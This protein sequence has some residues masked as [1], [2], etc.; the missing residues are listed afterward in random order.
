MVDSNLSEATMTIWKWCE[1]EEE[2]YEHA[3][4]M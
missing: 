1:H 4:I 3:Y 2:E